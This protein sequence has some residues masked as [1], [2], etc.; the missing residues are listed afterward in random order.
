VS[1]SGGIEPEPLRKA[2]LEVTRFN[3]WL[4]A[5]VG[6][7][8]DGEGLQG[9]PEAVGLPSTPD[10]SATPQ[11][12]PEES[13]FAGQLSRTSSIVNRRSARGKSASGGGAD[14]CG[15]ITP[16]GQS[17]AS[18]RPDVDLR[19]WLNLPLGT[20]RICF[21]A[22][23]Q[24]SSSRFSSEPGRDSTEAPRWLILASCSAAD[25]GN[26]ANPSA[27]RRDRKRLR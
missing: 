27:A 22:K 9:N 24:S 1:F 19:V 8:E 18:G 26:P 11:N 4:G 12:R 20:K 16:R 3:S 21:R 14:R 2:Y 25:S 10:W 17:A 13:G 15:W 5:I 7:S 23:T 6:F